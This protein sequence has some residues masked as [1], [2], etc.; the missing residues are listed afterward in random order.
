MNDTNKDRPFE[1]H[2]PLDR[3][4][5]RKRWEAGEHFEFYLFYG[6]KQK[7]GDVDASCLSQWFERDFTID[8]VEYA[9]AEHWMM[10]EKAR[11]FED[12]FMLE[13]ILD[14]ESPKEAKAFGRK[15]QNFDQAAWEQHRFEIV[16]RGNYAK[17]GQNDD[18]KEFLFSTA[19]NSAYDYGMVAE[20]RTGYEIDSKYEEDD[21]GLL[22]FKAEQTENSSESAVNLS[23]SDFKSSN[24]I[25]VEAAGRDMIWGIGLGQHNPKSKDPFQWRGRNL[26]GFA[27]TVVREQL[28]KDAK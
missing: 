1:T 12:A 24:V 20:P 21:R 19:A 4:E 9:T 23:N 25:L 8:G 15:V 26:L 22:A 16:R 6:H 28:L 17:F 5:L 7:F 14:S 3:K 10:A 18:L 27:L 2:L 13:A 11:L